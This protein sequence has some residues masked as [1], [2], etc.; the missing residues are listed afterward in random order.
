MGEPTKHHLVPEC[1]LK[2]FATESKKLLQV[3]DK[4]LAKKGKPKTPA[5]VGYEIDAFMIRSE[6]TLFFE[7]VNDKY[8][9]EKKGFRKLENSY[10]KILGKIKSTIGNVL[11]L[12]NQEA[13]N[14]LGL[15]LNIKRRSNDFRKLFLDIENRKKDLLQ[16]IQE[17]LPSIKAAAEMV[18]EGENVEVALER[19]VER[20]L[21]SKDRLYDGYLIQLVDTAIVDGLIDKLKKLKWIIATAPINCHFITS[22]NPGFS[23][24][25]ANTISRFGGFGEK[26]IFVFPITPLH[27]F[28]NRRQI[29]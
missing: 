9:I 20:V 1:Y 14:F 25:Q 4:G 15:L 17:N 19:E 24:N 7:K 22:D 11:Y 29:C 23:I 18:G 2:E 13:A 3:Y 10:P 16:R 8:E 6:E 28:N 5:Q 27:A 21:N 12:N 26:F